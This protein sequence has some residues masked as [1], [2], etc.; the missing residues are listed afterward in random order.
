MVSFTKTL[1]VEA[2]VINNYSGAT[3]FPVDN[4]HLGTPSSG[5]ANRHS[6]DDS[7]CLLFVKL[8][9]DDF[10]LVMWNWYWC[11]DSERNSTWL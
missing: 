5:S 9:L 6:F 8:F 2:L 4:D 3:V 10:L 7:A 1:T 11:V